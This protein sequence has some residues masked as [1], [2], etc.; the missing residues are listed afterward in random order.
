VT[1][2]TEDFIAERGCHRAGFSRFVIARKS[3]LLVLRDMYFYFTSAARS[4]TII[5]SE[6]KN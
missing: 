2:N 1:T 5:R 6:R 4:A 3:L